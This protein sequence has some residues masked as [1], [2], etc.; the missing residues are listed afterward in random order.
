MAEGDIF[1]ASIIM[2]GDDSTSYVN[3]FGFADKASGSTVID[4]GTAAGDFQTLVQA[5]YAAVLPSDVQI[6]RYRFAC[7]SGPHA[8]D[9]GYVDVSP[10]VAGSATAL[11]RMPNEIAVSLKRGTGRTGRDHRG[12]IFFGPVSQ[13]IQA[14]INT[15]DTANADLIAVAN[16]LKANFTTQ[17]RTLTPVLVKANGTT[18]G[19]TIQRAAIATTFV[20]RRSRRPREGS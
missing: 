14:D 19:Y 2:R 11:N 13:D 7:V 20:H 4:T 16:L 5:K 9:V 3:D 1:R 18:N 17:T 8:G 6:V 12:R 15:V 10:P